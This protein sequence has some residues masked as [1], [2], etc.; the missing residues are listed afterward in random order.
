MKSFEFLKMHGLEN[1]FVIFDNNEEI[2]TKNIKKIGS[3]ILDR[4]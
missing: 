1:D 3:E 2:K 4:L